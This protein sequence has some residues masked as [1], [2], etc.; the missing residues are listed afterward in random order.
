M[1]SSPA[2]VPALALTACAVEHDAEPE[3]PAG[4]AADDDPPTDDAEAAEPATTLI[5]ATF[6]LEFAPCDG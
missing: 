6:D 1:W 2:I 5:I 4:E 3:T